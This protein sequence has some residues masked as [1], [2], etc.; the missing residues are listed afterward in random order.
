MIYPQ[1]IHVDMDAFF[2]AVE[3]RDNPELRGK[4]LIIGSLPSERGVVST[5]SY[6]ARKYGVRSAMSIKDAYRRCPH[7]I[8][9]HPNGH[10]YYEVSKQIH[11]I[12]DKYTD[13]CE[14][15]SLDEGFL[16]VT[17]SAH[18]FG[19]A[20]KIGGEIKHRTVETVGLTCSVGIGYSLMSAK[21][22]SEEKKPDGYF[23]IPTPKALRELI[24]DRNVR[25]IYG[26]GAKT[27]D[28]LKRIGITTVRQIYENPQL[29]TSLLGNHG[30]QIIELAEGIDNRKV[31]PFAEAKSIGAEHTFQHD[32][33]DFAYLKDVLLLTAQRI[34]FDLKLKGI[35]AHTVTLKVTYHDMKSITRSK[36]GDATDKTQV[37]FD[38]AA[39]LLDKIERRP[40]RLVG[41]SLS[42]I[43]AT[44]NMQ[45]S[46]FDA[47]DDAQQSKLDDAMLTLQKKYGRGI[48]KT[49]NVL[50]AEKRV[51]DF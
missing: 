31:T 45:I 30:R 32:T 24:I 40:I 8:Y 49:A 25:E 50:G 10:K 2:A 44:P 9:M 23:E 18:L 47:G 3:V 19:G 48:V 7:G 6:E 1:I 17:A 34:S 41:I 28:E 13:L 42:N 16:D 26:V 35:Y 39:A 20:A 37:I 43:S 15:I 5:C 4:P 36:S 21:L 46:L 22:A 33:T 29:V 14:C 11:E 12:W 38:T 27:A 51:G